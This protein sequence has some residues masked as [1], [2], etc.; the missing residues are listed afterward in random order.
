MH[1][2]NPERTRSSAYMEWVKTQTPARFGL[3][4][5][6]MMFCPLSF[7]GGTLE[8]LEVNGPSFYGYEPLVRA[9]AQH[10]GVAPENVVCAEGTSM[11]NHLAM[12]SLVEPGDEVLVEDPT[13]ELLLSLAGY[14]GARIKRF[15]RGRETRFLPDPDDLAAVMSSRTKLIVLT[16]LHNPSSAWMP[17]SLL[18]RIGELA[19]QVGARVLVDEV[20]L[21][22][23]GPTPPPSAFHLGPEFVTTNSLTKVYGLNGLRCGWALA[24]P[25]LARKMWRLNDLFGVIPS[26]LSERLS[27]IAFRRMPD[28]R[29]RTLEHL[30]V[31]QAAFRSILQPHPR[32][33]VCAPG[34]G[35]I[36]F[37]RLKTGDATEFCRFLRDRYQTSVV[38]GT[39]F[40][41]PDH[42]RIGLGGPC[43]TVK[44][45]LEQVRTALEEWNP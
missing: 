32:L 38:P 33:E 6:G 17:E 34:Y 8:D 16:Q 14:L 7:L 3:L 43:E 22:A 13:Y 5:S 26:H 35:T 31:N 21:E 39:F 19:R 41:H 2:A 40:G 11:V 37:P 28:L 23:M 1:P 15:P 12:A 9:V 30:Q 4:T 20:Y 18:R 44:A 27:V 36:V 24:E 45:G 25:A 10:S 42:F 29:R